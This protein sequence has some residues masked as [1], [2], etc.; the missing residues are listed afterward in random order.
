MRE[1]EV[2]C[3]CITS[4][5]LESIGHQRESDIISEISDKISSPS[6][7][8]VRG[9]EPVPTAAIL[10]KPLRGSRGIIM[11]GL[12]NALPLRS[13]ALCEYRSGAPVNNNVFPTCPHGVTLTREYQQIGGSLEPLQVGRPLL[14]SRD[15]RYRW[16]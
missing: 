16:W 15:V 1:S 9:S 7:P 2:I 3:N 14:S 4:F 6:N 13:T 10:W 5:P 12:Y 8:G 11:P